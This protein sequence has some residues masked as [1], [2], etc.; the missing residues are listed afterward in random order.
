MAE[1]QSQFAGSIP[2]NYD[3]Y[4]VPI[5]FQPF[6]ES[7]A[8]T[9]GNLNPKSVLELACGTGAVTR[10]LAEAL[11][12]EARLI[13][14]DLSQD[15][16]E[17]ARQNLANLPRIEFEVAD[18]CQLPFEDGSFDLIVCQFGAMSFP[19]RPAAMSEAFRV[20]S[21]AGHL[22]FNTWG[23][24]AKNPIFQIVEETLTAMFPDEETPFMPTP[25]S[26]ADPQLLRNLAGNAGFD[27]VIVTEEHQAAGSR[28][29][30]SI[31][32]GF[33]YGT[34][35]GSYLSDQGYNLDE[36]HEA[37]TANFAGELG[38]PISC[39]MQAVICHAAKS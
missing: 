23:N 10:C 33:A 11:P 5:L 4:L 2:Q 22:L 1:S 35:L 27:S 29:P 6:A 21:P 8:A 28:D 37:L 26:M 12:D 39:S 30:S 14:T 38:N 13:A 9:A 3:R 15:M 19:D 34:P 24:I 17:I 36:I 16:L 20:L 32:A 18:A 25:F 7:M 31:A